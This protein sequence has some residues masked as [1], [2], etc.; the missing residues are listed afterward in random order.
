MKNKLLLSLY[1][2]IPLFLFTFIFISVAFMTNTPSIPADNPVYIDNGV[3]YPSVVIRTENEYQYKEILIERMMANNQVI[4]NNPDNHIDSITPTQNKNEKVVYL[5]I[6]DGPSPAIT[7]KMLDILK[8]YNVK[9]TF[10][11]IGDLIPGNEAIL[12]RIID[13]GHAIGLH[14]YT[15]DIKSIYVTEDS[16]IN[17][18]IKT[19]DELTRVLGIKT[20]IIRFPGGST[21]H[22]NKAFLNRL[23][24][25]QYKIYDWNISGGDGM[26]P[27]NRPDQIFSNAT[28]SEQLTSKAILLMHTKSNN[29]TSCEALPM[30]IDFYIKNGYVFKP[31]SQSTPEYYFKF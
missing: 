19:S 5:T 16:L 6:D 29:Q 20:N 31:I 28:D 21:G 27:K 7:L 26:Y 12:K 14:S 18:M 11:I 25:L 13:D 4:K 15:H 17:E 30:I 24:E 9:A 22:L 8:K 10:F 3:S 1:V 2:V 23:H